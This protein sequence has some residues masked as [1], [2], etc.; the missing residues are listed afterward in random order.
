MKIAHIVIQEAVTHF[1]ANQPINKLITQLF[2]G[3]RQVQDSFEPVKH[4]SFMKYEDGV[5]T[6]RIHLTNALPRILD[7]IE[8]REDMDTTF[9]ISVK[10]LEAEIVVSYDKPSMWFN[11]T[12]KTFDNLFALAVERS[13]E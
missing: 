11:I 5:G 12:S 13:K 4:F 6:M 2:R 10:G 3:G 7:S 8:T 1:L 9:T